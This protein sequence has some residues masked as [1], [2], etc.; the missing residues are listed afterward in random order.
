ME[1]CDAGCARD[2]QFASS[3][4]H[5]YCS[6]EM[7]E[8]RLHH[9]TALGSPATRKANP[10]TADCTIHK[11]KIV[12]ALLAFDSCRYITLYNR[13]ALTRPC[14]LGKRSNNFIPRTAWWLIGT[15]DPDCYVTYTRGCVRLSKR[16]ALTHSLT[17]VV[18]ALVRRRVSFY[19]TTGT[20]T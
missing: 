15:I 18:R 4:A 17:C 20:H 8:T 19:A 2:A 11:I 16:Q 7:F 3:I 13:H 14:S 5:A 10:I 12:N 9:I 6:T 1:Q